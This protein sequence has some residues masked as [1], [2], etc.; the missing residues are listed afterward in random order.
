M[1]PIKFFICFITLC[2][3]SDITAKH[4]IS[5]SMTYECLG[6]NEY[7]FTMIIYR[8][9]FGGGAD[10]DN[11]A[12]ISIFKN[13][14]EL[15]E[16]LEIQITTTEIVEPV[17]CSGQPVQYCSEKAI[18]KFTT[19]LLD[20]VAPY[21]IVYQR[22]CWS[23]IVANI[24]N[25]E[26]NGITVVSTVSELALEICNS[27]TIIDMPLAFAA[28]PGE[29]IN[30]P[31]LPF[32]ADGDSLAFEI[33]LP[34]KGGGLGG[35]P[36][37]PGDPTACD[38]VTPNPACPPP[39]EQLSFADGFSIDNPFPTNNGIE[40]D[41]IN[42]NI[43]FTP[44]SQGV[45]IYGLC[46][47]EYRDGQILGRS[48]H[49]IETTSGINIINIEET[50]DLNSWEMTQ[51]FS[52]QELSF[53]SNIPSKNGVI[54]LYDATGKNRLSKNIENQNK[55]TIN[56]SHLN[57]GIYFAKLDSDNYSKTFKVVIAQ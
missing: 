9:C 49:N 40:V 15:I 31:I 52:N 4:I 23:D 47:T 14:D 45:Y 44:S 18:Y 53:T 2:F 24:L 55:V 11:P 26:E 32:D 7:E 13:E 29:E 46:I 41:P 42:G 17:F 33:C 27:Q 28:C 5:G 30:I 35:T 22:C 57:A 21:N 1:S 8:D 10:F 56:T 12:A 37:F 34:Y 48:A 36:G 50:V 54:S 25:P 19:T 51:S 16:T 6:N 20:G 3:C 38:G 39:Y 43:S